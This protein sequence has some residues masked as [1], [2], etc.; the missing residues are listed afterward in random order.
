MLRS[1]CSECSSPRLS[2]VPARDLP[3]RVPPAERVEAAEVVAFFHDSL[4]TSCEAWLCR[5]CSGF[6]IIQTGSFGLV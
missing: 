3:S 1:N 2:W 5:D 6:G 4:G